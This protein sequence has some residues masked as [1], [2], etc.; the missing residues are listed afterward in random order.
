MYQLKRIL[1][2]AVTV[3]VTLNLTACGA[4]A[5]LE[6]RIPE[7]CQQGVPTVKN[8]FTLAGWKGSYRLGP[9]NLYKG[10]F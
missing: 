3:A 10:D 5:S 6:S 9:F 2:L 7:P 1:T 4:W 8:C